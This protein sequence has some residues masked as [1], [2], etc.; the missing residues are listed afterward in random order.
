[1]TVVNSVVKYA[2]SVHTHTHTHTHTHSLSL[3]LS[4]SLSHTHTHTHTLGCVPHVVAA[5]FFDEQDDPKRGEDPEGE[6]VVGAQS[7]TN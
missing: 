7:G 4:L 2:L 1:V 6:G 3:S 5:V